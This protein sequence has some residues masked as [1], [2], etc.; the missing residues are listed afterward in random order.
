M[1][2]LQ[3]AYAFIDDN[4]PPMEV[5]TFLRC[6]ESV[7]MQTCTFRGCRATFASSGEMQSHIYSLHKHIPSSMIFAAQMT[8]RE[9]DRQ[10]ITIDESGNEEIPLSNAPP[11]PAK[12]SRGPEVDADDDIA[13]LGHIARVADNGVARCMDDDEA[14]RD[15][16]YE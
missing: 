16:C 10:W 7:P 12:R 15:C 14:T 1:E 2:A 11:T 5:D 13:F 6:V 4:C 3:N 9:C 8:V